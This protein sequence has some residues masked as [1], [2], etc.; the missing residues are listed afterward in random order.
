MVNRV[1]VAGLTRVQWLFSGIAAI[2]LQAGSFIPNS[3]IGPLEALGFILGVA[4]VWL[5]IQESPWN[6]PIG[7]ANSLIYIVVMIQGKIYGDAALNALYVVLGCMG[8]YW[9]VR[10]DDGKSA[11]K[12][13]RSRPTLLTLLAVLGI[14]VAVA[15][16]PYFK[17]AG[18][19]VAWPD[20]FLFSFS[21]VGQYLQTRKKLE[22]WPVWVLVDFGYI[23]VFIY[24]QFYATAVLYGI[25]GLLALKGWQSWNEAEKKVSA[26]VA[27]SS[28][29]SPIP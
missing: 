6:W 27:S 5:L 4:W 3:P 19:T 21:L 16:A 28:D 17:S 29:A 2:S 9:W 25:Y 20:A 24:K 1:K 18:S 11:L 14:A 13:T 10:G 15:L 8:W 26:G 23:P 22:N 12:I 7:I